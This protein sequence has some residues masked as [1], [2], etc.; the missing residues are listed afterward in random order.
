[1]EKDLSPLG[2]YRFSLEDRKGIDP[3]TL[4]YFIIGLVIADII[5]YKL[6]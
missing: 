3:K 5:I 4:V 1:M 2:I 6:L